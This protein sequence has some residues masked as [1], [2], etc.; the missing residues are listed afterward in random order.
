MTTVVNSTAPTARSRIGRRLA[1]KARQSVRQAL[2]VAYG[3]KIAFRVDER[4]VS[5]HRADAET[6]DPAIA[7]FLDFLARDIEQRPEAIKALS[8]ALVA[9]IAGLTKDME[10]DPGEEIDDEVAL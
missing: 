9:R 2:G 7:S 1:L 3:G 8:P 10:L 5:V 4:G 6:D